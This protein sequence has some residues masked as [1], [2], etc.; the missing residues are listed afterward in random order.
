M[1]GQID[2]WLNTKVGKQLYGWV[3]RKRWVGRH[4]DGWVDGEDSYV[5]SEL[6]L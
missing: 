3:Y 4:L 5:D 2:E 6:G 1:G